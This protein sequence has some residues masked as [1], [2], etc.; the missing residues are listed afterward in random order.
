M[1]NA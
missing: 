1:E